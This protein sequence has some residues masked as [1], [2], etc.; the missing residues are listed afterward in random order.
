VTQGPGSGEH[1]QQRS[2]ENKEAI[3]RAPINPSGDHLTSL[4]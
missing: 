2:C 1:Q 4:L 3:S